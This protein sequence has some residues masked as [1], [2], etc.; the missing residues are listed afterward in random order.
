MIKSELIIGWV[1]AIGL[2]VTLIY[3]ISQYHQ[4]RK[5]YQESPDM[6]L[7]ADQ[8]LD[9]SVLGALGAAGRWV[10]TDAS[11]IKNTRH[12]FSFRKVSGDS[13]VGT[14]TTLA[15]DELYHRGARW[16][17]F[18][19]APGDTVVFR[20]YDGPLRPLY[21]LDGSALATNLV[22]P[23]R[24]A[25]AY[26]GRE[27]DFNRLEI[28]TLNPNA[29]FIVTLDSGFPGYAQYIFVPLDKEDIFWD[30]K[31]FNVIVRDRELHW[32]EVTN[33]DTVKFVFYPGPLP[34]KSRLVKDW[35]PRDDL[36]NVVYPV[37]AN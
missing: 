35:M 33:G 27:G 9:S 23:Q 24:I 37:K 31:I 32:R 28:L 5:Q 16:R 34:R 14:S 29:R 22:Y 3:S 10:V 19:V 25:N 26:L 8:T 30:K 18:L 17:W 7:A 13:G 21:K 11:T 2:A 6:T 4:T 15:L 1:F 20:R 12:R 36:R